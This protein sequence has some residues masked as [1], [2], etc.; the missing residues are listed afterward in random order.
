LLRAGADPAEA[1][2]QATTGAEIAE[3][4]VERPSAEA[5]AWRPTVHAAPS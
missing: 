4:A 2:A 3:Q 1:A 5:T